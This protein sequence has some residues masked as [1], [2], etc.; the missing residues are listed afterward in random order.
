[1]IQFAML[2]KYTIEYVN[3]ADINEAS[4]ILIDDLMSMVAL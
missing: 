3:V 1:M 4:M 2:K